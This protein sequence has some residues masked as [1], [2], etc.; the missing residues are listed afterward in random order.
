MRP[1]NTNEKIEYSHVEK[2]IKERCISLLQNEQ[3]LA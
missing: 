1:L 3:M 2:A